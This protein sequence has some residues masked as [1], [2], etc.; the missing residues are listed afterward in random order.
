M[1]TK[2]KKTVITN[3]WLIAIAFIIV[4]LSVHFLTCTNYELLR[5]E[6]LFFNMGEHLDFGYATVPP[7]TGFPALLM[8]NTF[9]FSVF[10]IRLF[11]AV[12]GAISVYIIALTV[13]DPVAGIEALFTPTA[14]A[15]DIFEKYPKGP[16][17][18][19]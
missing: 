10:G 13:K 19:I 15:G 8:H 1:K 3:Y 9:G 5:D 2:L 7:M 12:M 14:F 11:P 16:R 17:S 6:M 18:S 4:K